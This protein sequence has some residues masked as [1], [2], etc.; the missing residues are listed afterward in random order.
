MG[1]S[2]LTKEQE[3]LAVTLHSLLGKV[4]GSAADPIPDPEDDADGNYP[5]VLDEYDDSF[6]KELAKALE[7]ATP[8]SLAR[9]KREK[10]L[11]LFVGVDEDV[12]AQHVDDGDDGDSD[13]SDEIR[14]LLESS[15]EEGT[16]DLAW[17]REHAVDLG[18]VKKKEAKGLR[19]KAAVTAIVENASLED[20]KEALPSDDDP[21]DDDDDGDDDSEEKLAL[22]K[23][24][25]IGALRDLALSFALASEK[26]LTK[27]RSKIA[28]AEMFED[29]PL[30][31]IQAGLQPD[32]DPDDGDEDDD[33]EDKPKPKK[34]KTKKNKKDK[35]KKN[36][37]G[38]GGKKKEVDDGDEDDGPPWNY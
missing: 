2:N 32:D 10:L 31:D 37:K 16:I 23:G 33:P 28:I 1:K 30:D 17:L 3:V 27:M 36:K 25:Q 29:V 5:S 15:V 19:T 26:K 35:T 38:K 18:G 21:E 6:L 22:L 8:R 12:I 34:D 11:S 4:L 9:M 14:S 7:L 20:V 24:L 13:D